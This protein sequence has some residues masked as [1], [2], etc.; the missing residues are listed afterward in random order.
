MRCVDQAYGFIPPPLSCCWRFQLVQL[1]HARRRH[2]CAKT[3]VLKAARSEALSR[4][5]TFTDDWGLVLGVYLLWLVNA[6]AISHLACRLSPPGSFLHEHQ[7]KV[8]FSSGLITT[9]GFVALTM[10]RIGVEVEMLN[11]PPEYR[12]HVLAELATAGGAVAMYAPE[13]LAHV[14]LRSYDSFGRVRR[15]SDTGGGEGG[16]GAHQ[17]A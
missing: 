4:P 12:R 11:V 14:E 8:V 5:L 15:G 9:I 17:M 10:C 13:A 1:L 3:Q 16:G 7:L 2:C 6:L